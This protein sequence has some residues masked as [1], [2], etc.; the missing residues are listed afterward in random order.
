MFLNGNK[1][2]FKNPNDAIVNGHISKVHQETN[3]VKDLTVGQNI[4]LGYEPTK[5]IFVDYSSMNRRVDEILAK[6]KC[7]F[8][9]SDVAGTLTSGEMQ[10]MAIAKAL[11]HNST[12]ISLDEPTASLT[13]KETNALFEVINELKES[14]ITVIYV[15]HRL[16]EIFQICDRAT[17][18]RDGEYINTLD[19]ASTTREELI[20]NMVGRN[21]AAVASRLKESPIEDEIVLK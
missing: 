8:R 13:L 10:M 2:L 15:S 18:L 16:E 11:F 12:I 3:V 20:R 9:S 17:I 1:V 4:T 14:G 19:V 7:K 21:V 5:G 6:L